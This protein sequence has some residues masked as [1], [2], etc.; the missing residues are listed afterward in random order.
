MNALAFV[1]FIV[2]VTCVDDGISITYPTFRLLSR[3]K[4]FRDKKSYLLSYYIIMIY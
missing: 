4:E 2:V 3:S 1:E